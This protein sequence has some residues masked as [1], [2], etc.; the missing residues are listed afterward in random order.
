MYTYNKHKNTVLIQRTRATGKQTDD[1]VC[2]VSKQKYK[3]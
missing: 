3:A 1:T 2:G